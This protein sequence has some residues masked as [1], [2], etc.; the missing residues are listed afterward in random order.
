MCIKGIHFAS[1]STF[2]L[3]DFVTVL[4]FP[5]FITF[6]IQLNQNVLMAFFTMPIPAT[7]FQ[8]SVSPGYKPW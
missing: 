4:Y 2:F 7:C 3:L 6:Y 1:I 5:H 8:S